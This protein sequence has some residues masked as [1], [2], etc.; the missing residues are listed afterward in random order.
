[1]NDNAALT[2]LLSIM[3]T[4]RDPKNGC[5]WDLKQDFK[6]IVP[7]TLEEAYEVADCIES[8]NLGE[9]KGELGDLLFQIVFYAQL[10]QEQN[11]FDFSDVIEQLNTK[12]TRRHPHVFDDKKELTDEQLS[13]QWQAIK[14]QERSTRAQTKSPSFWQDIPANM[15]SLSKAKKIQQRVASLGF[16]WPTY[17]GALDKVSE[18]VLEVKEAIEQDPSSDHTA[19]ELGDLLFATVNVVR[20]VKRDPEQLLRSANDKFSARFEKVQVYLSA[21]GKSLDTATFEEM[22]RAWDAIKKL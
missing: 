20:H 10:A 2:Q 17:H 12:L 1:M 22:D 15:P 13:Q 7:H 3:K 11:L 4:L 18:E 14:A 19:E 5:P 8:G 16:D 21:Q 6:S 9:L